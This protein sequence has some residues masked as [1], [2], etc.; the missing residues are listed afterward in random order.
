LQPDRLELGIQV[1]L[2]DECLIKRHQGAGL[3]TVAN[4][5]VV[6]KAVNNGRKVVD[7]VAGY[8][9]PVACTDD[10]AVHLT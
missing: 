5:I 9:R 3:A 4:G 10:L 8:L 1:P 2:A 6:S 7:A